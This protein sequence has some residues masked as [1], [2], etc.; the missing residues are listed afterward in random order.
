[1]ELLVDPNPVVLPTWWDVP[2]GSSSP[3]PWTKPILG[4]CSVQ[5]GPH[6]GGNAW[7]RVPSWS[8][9]TSIPRWNR[10]VELVERKKSQLSSVLKIQ[11]YLLECSEMKAQ[12]RE[13]RKAIE[14]TQSGSGDLGGVLALQRR[15]STMEAALVVLEPRLVELQQEGEALAASHPGRALEILLPFEQISEEWEALKRALQGCEDSLTIA[16]R[17]QQFIQDLDNFLGWLVKTQAAVACQEV[18]DSLSEAERLLN[19]HTALKEEI[20][21]YEED[22][23][24]IQAASDLL[25][26][27]E[28]EVPYLSLQQWLQK[29]DAGWGKLLQSWETRREVL[30]QSHV[31][32][33]FLRDV[34]Q[35]QTSLY[36]QV[37]TGGRRSGLTTRLE[38][39][40]E[41]KN[42]EDRRRR[43]LPSLLQ[44]SA[45]VHAE[46]PD[47]VEG[48]TNAIKK[49]KDFTTTMEL[50]LQKIQQTLQAGE[51]LQRQGNL[52]SDRVAQ[53][54]EGLRTK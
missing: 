49:H 44:E 48:V 2:V 16:G 35:C 17:L 31:F 32:H 28:M 5:G 8:C 4:V 3:V 38:L 50:N 12:V 27:E 11:N 47:T 23:A 42:G 53:E 45:L 22:Y 52:Y 30:V 33:L 10:V 1:M 41:E 34:Q 37:K 9:P 24:K 46:L 14:A 18:P 15:L 7:C 54:M 20:N 43:L 39:G 40:S 19:H 29:L 21:G 51:S 6:P 36:N 26:L 13:K 25:A